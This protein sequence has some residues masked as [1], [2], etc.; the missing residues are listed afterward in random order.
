MLDLLYVVPGSVDLSELLQ[1]GERASGLCLL[2]SRAAGL[3]FAAARRGKGRIVSD[4]RKGVCQ[5]TCL[6]SKGLRAAVGD[7]LLQAPGLE[8]T[9]R[10]GRELKGVHW[11]Q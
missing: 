10:G 9:M 6:W 4:R 3:G 11:Y 7:G 1:A 5:C 2:S 8:F